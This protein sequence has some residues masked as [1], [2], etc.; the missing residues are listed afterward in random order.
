MDSVLIWYRGIIYRGH[1]GFW[2]L[3]YNI[4]QFPKLIGTYIYCYIN[5][6]SSYMFNPIISFICVC[7]HVK[8]IQQSLVLNQISNMRYCH[9]LI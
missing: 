9:V 6:Y 3:I 5:M 2:D 1:Y 8:I 7:I 4:S